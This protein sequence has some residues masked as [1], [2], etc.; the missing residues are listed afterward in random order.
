MLTPYIKTYK[1]LRSLKEY[2]LSMGRVCLWIISF[3][4]MEQYTTSS[5]IGH[6]KGFKTNASDKNHSY[7]IPL[8]NRKWS[9]R[10]DYVRAI[11]AIVEDKCLLSWLPLR[12]QSKSN[13]HING[14]LIHRSHVLEWPRFNTMPTGM[15]D[16][17]PEMC[18]LAFYANLPLF[19]TTNNKSTLWE[20]H[21]VRASRLQRRDSGYE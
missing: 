3:F 11:N 19:C 14:S 13:P 21:S 2:N 6:M 8:Q 7:L 20:I 9:T 5:R 10:A 4:P 17:R 15:P 18:P 12:K 1:D 16:T